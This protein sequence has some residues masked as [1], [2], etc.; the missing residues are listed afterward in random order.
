MRRS[1]RQLTSWQ[2]EQI[3]S[4][5]CVQ[6]F[7]IERSLFGGCRVAKGCDHVDANLPLLLRR[8]LCA[9]RRRRI[10]PGLRQSTAVRL[11]YKDQ[12]RAETRPKYTA[13]CTA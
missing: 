8:Q 7:E 12:F 5:R 4:I 13:E 10:L 6:R 3:F 9:C 1:P 2:V 11:P